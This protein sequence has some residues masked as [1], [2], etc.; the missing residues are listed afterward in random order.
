MNDDQIDILSSYDSNNSN[1]NSPL[2]PHVKKKRKLPNDDP[3]TPLNRKRKTSESSGDENWQRP[4]KCPKCLEVFSHDHFKWNKHNIDKHI[5]SH[6]AKI[7]KSMKA[8][9]N[10]PKIIKFFSE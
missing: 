2:T 5:N 4:D 10:S 8:D 1:L 3:K 6:N 7:S 9:A